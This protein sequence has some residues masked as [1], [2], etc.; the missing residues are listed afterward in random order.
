MKNSQGNTTRFPNKSNQHLSFGS[1][2]ER[3]ACRFLEMKGLKLIMQNYSCKV[4]EIDLIMQDQ[5]HI[6]FVEVRG[7]H[8]IDYGNAFE[9]IIP[10]KQKKLIR[11]ATCF[12]QW[13]KCLY[14]VNSRFDIVALHPVNGQLTIEW[15]KNAF[16]TRW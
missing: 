15:I 4:G 14:T 13:K 9:S 3:A 7:R 2:T 10:A 1:A 5:D 11:A 16:T 12:L 6:V 8:R